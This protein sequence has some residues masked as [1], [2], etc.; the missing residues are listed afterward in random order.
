MVQKM[1][2]ARGM[3]LAWPIPKCRMRSRVAA[4]IRKMAIGVQNHGKNAK[5]QVVRRGNRLL[6]SYFTL[7]QQAVP[8]QKG[9]V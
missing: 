8:V 9:S 1:Q 2:I 3:A 5:N 4:H 7:Q 6:P